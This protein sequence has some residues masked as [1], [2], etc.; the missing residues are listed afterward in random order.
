M[1]TGGAQDSKHTTKLFDVIL[2]WEKGGPVQQLPQDAAHSPEVNTL[3][4]LAGTIQELGGS[5]PPGGHLVC[6]EAV[7]IWGKD[8]GQAKVCYLELA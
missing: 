2:S 8:P 6:V 1:R 4:V 5:V 7:A 3:I